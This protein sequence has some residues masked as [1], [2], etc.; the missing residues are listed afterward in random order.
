MNCKEYQKAGLWSVVSGQLSAKQV[1]GPLRGLVMTNQEDDALPAGG[2]GSSYF[3]AST[4]FCWSGG[5]AWYS[6]RKVPL[7][8][9]KPIMFSA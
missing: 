9:P 6:A 5:S 7:V 2:S 1:S 8:Q 3:P 4:F